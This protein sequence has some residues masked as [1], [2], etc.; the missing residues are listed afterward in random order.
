MATVESYYLSMSFGDCRQKQS[1]VRYRLTTIAAQAWLN[2]ADAAA[3]AATTVGVLV[4]K[5]N[6]LT[7]ATLISW[8]VEL[9]SAN[10]AAIYPVGD[11]GVY[12]FDK[13][14][15][16][17]KAGLKNYTSTIPARNDTA[18]NV[19]ADGVNVILTGAG[20]SAAVTEFISAYEAVVL[21]DNGLVPDIT[22]MYIAQ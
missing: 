12:N 2:A 15:V 17:T 11:S 8:G 18:I 5:V 3:R 14:S 4:T 1:N 7:D 21:A 22:G 9:E 20:A 10:D 6:A 19:G 16:Q 13:V